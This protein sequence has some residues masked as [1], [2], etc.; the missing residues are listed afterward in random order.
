MLEAREIDEPPAK[1]APVGEGGDAGNL[2]IGRLK[3]QDIARRLAE[4]KRLVAFRY[5]T[6]LGKQEMHFTQLRGA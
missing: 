2:G 6:F 5:R 1:V 3:E 4:I